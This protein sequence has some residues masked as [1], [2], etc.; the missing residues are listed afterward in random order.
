MPKY[1]T[2]YYAIHINAVPF[3][4]VIVQSVNRITNIQS[5]SITGKPVILFSTRAFNAVTTKD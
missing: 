2:S 3:F 1:A 5:S 4:L